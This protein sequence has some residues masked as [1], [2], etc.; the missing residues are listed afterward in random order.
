LSYRPWLLVTIVS[1]LSYVH[2]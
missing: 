1:S 2:L